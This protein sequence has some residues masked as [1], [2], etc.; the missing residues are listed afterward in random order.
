MGGQKGVG[1]WR[2]VEARKNLQTK[3]EWGGGKKVWE[4]EKGWK[5]KKLWEAGE[6]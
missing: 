5:A 3:G 6:K 2:E 4:A 1:G